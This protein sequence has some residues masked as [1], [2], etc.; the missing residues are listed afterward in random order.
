[1]Q[2]SHT[3]EASSRSPTQEFPNILWNPK[4]YYRVHKNFMQNII[5]NIGAF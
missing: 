4:F 5:L 1:M 2:L 3:W